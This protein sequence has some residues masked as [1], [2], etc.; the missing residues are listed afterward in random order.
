M[1]ILWLSIK[2]PL[3]GL[4]AN[5]DKTSLVD[6]SLYLNFFVVFH[7]FPSP[8][9]DILFIIIQVSDKV[10]PSFGVRIDISSDSEPQLYVLQ[11][12]GHLAKFIKHI[13]NQKAVLAK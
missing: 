12:W 3:R 1:I 10:W 6:L 5:V 7:H 13:Y 2:L 4:S 8:S 9:Q 11:A